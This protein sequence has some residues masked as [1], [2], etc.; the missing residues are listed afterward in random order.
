MKLIRLFAPAILAVT[1][2]A[3]SAE[4]TNEGE[5][6]AKTECTEA[7]GDDCD[8]KKDCD[9]KKACCSDKKD[10]D[11]KE[12]CDGEKGKCEEGKCEEGKCESG[13]CESGKESTDMST[14][15]A[16]EKATE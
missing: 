13:K 14:T 2:M 1:L 8:H 15:E 16:P 7:C 3:C 5:E 12:K 9:G 11:C 6:S 10:H 4:A